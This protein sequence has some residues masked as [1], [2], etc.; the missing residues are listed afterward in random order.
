MSANSPLHG[1]V[2]PHDAGHTV[3]KSGGPKE[4]RELRLVV[5]MK[6]L[7][8][9]TPGECRGTANQLQANPAAAKASVDRRIEQERVCAAIGRDM[10][11][12]N[13]PVS[14]EG[15]EG[16]EASRK[17][18]LKR[19]RRVI[20]PRPRKQVIQIRIIE[21]RIYAIVDCFSHRSP[22]IQ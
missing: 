13:E 15:S 9:S 19:A 20:G 14:H 16:S 12:T 2:E 4:R 21:R 8:A 1:A 7:T 10:N 22:G 11:E 6:P 5:D 17:D 3:A 18:R